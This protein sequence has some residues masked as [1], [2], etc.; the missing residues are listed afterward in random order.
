MY[1]KILVPTIDLKRSEKPLREAI[2]LAN[3][4]GW[5]TRITVLHVNPVPIFD[6]ES[7]FLDFLA[8]L[9]EVGRS[10]LRSI[11]P[12]LAEAQIAHESVSVTGDPAYTIYSKANSE[13]YDLLVI[14]K[15]RQNSVVRFF[16][17]SI[18]QTILQEA[19][20]PILQVPE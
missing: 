20:C 9:E 16:R 14:G 1:K 19:R 13:K 2:R 15:R 8:N 17:G 11:E 3:L 6:Q 4:L 7:L 10:I 18:S 5:D 12:L